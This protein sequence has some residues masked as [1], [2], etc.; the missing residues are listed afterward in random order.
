MRVSYDT[1]V[2]LGWKEGTVVLY[3][4]LGRRGAGGEGGRR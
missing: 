1:A 4:L 3:K 2:K